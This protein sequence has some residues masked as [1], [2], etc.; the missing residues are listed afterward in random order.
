MYVYKFDR[1][2]SL[3]VKYNINS[4]LKGVGGLWSMGELAE[5]PLKYIPNWLKL[6]GL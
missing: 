2:V 1:A 6:K 4:L 3:S 5:S